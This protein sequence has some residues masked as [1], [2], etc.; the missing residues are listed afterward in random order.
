MELK[1]AHSSPLEMAIPMV[2][3]YQ[4]KHRTCLKQLGL[5]IITGG[6]LVQ[7]DVNCIVR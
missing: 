7:C 6:G 5:C 1:F 2:Y 3:T 4:R